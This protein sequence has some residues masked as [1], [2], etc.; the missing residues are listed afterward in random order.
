MGY[1]TQEVMTV[2]EFSVRVL[3][4]AG[5][6]DLLKN[7]NKF[8]QFSKIVEEIGEFF[9]ATTEEEKEDA[10]G[11]VL[12]SVII[13]CYQVGIDFLGLFNLYTL[14]VSKGGREEI[15]DSIF[16]IADVLCHNGNLNSPLINIL[17]V[18]HGFTKDGL[19]EIFINVLHTIEKRTGKTINGMFIKE[20]K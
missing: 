18:T 11:D 12:V 10:I 2:E 5:K 17:A 6:R 8:S 9:T 13:F 1:L 4:W 14:K 3:Q 19:S 20:E 15:I 7:E 16:K